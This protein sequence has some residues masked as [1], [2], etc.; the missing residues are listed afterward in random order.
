MTRITKIAVIGAGIMGGGIVQ[1]CAQSGFM[2]SLMDLDDKIISR[3]IA[4]IQSSIQIL[5]SKGKMTSEEA[6]EVFG[7]IKSVSDLSAAVRDANL[8]IEAIPEKMDLK[9]Q[10][11]KDMDKICPPEVIF[12]TNTSSLSIAQIALA[13]EHPEKVI[14]LHFF[15]PVTI[16]KG[17]EVIPSL[18][19]SD[20]TLKTALNFT[21]DIGKESLVS[22][23]FPGF[24]V[25]RLLP[26]F[27]NEA[28]N[29]VW[30]GIAPAEEID[31]ACKL[32]LLHPIGPLEMADLIGLETVL[33]VLE[34]LH[35]ELGERYRPSPLLKQ[36]VNAGNYGKRHGKGIYD[37]RT[38]NPHFS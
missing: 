29:L 4:D 18:L 26:T 24:I 35:Q 17:V 3:S 16:S 31:R 28:F 6:E 36:L 33:S 21:K 30:Q 11:F 9:K 1:V 25:N 34:Y 13:T 7:R 12:A 14:G 2:V 37:Y 19:T 32:T 10:L 23:D 27:I 5:V 22:K 15:Y 8:V 20:E 38:I